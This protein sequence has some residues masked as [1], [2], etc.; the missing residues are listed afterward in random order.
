MLTLAYTRVSTDRQDLSTD[1]QTVTVQRAAAYLQ[2]GDPEIYADSDTSGSTPFAEREE[3]RELLER[4]REHVASTPSP[5]NGERAGVRGEATH[6]QAVTLLVPK[7][8]RLGRDSIDVNQT[9][10]LLDSL[11]V[12]VVFLDINV[13]T[14]TA[15]GRAFM[16]IAAVFA[17]LELARIRERIQTALDHKKSKGELCGTVPFGWDAIETG[18][19]SGKGVK[20]RKLVDN[21][22]EQNW[23]RR[24]AECRAEGWSYGS[25]ARMLNEHGVPTKKSNLP[26]RS[27]PHLSTSFQWQQGNVSKVLA[28]ATV[29]AW[30]SLQKSSAAA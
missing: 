24:M 4:I 8:D 13:D 6:D 30:L 11:G 22:V 19:V 27:A 28:N 20:I 14:R 23:I 25:I 9:V 16:Q 5:I 12:R 7:V 18:E 3:G 2:L 29:A 26:Q 1:A 21:F 10:R 15:M 17:E